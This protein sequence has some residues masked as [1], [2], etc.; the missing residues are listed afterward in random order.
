MEFQLHQSFE[1]LCM[2]LV[3]VHLKKHSTIIYQGSQYIFIPFDIQIS[4]SHRF[5]NFIHLVRLVQ[6]MRTAYLNDSM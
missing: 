5:A 6:L 1:C 2:R 4:K 3:K